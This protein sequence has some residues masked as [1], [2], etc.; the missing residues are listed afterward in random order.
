MAKQKRRYSPEFINYQKFIIKHP[1]YAEMPMP[2]KIK[3][4]IPWVTPGKGT[5]GKARAEWWAK[6]KGELVRQKILT[7][8]AKTSDVA[9]YIHPTKF[10]PCQTCGKSLS[11]EYVYLNMRGK[12]SFK[13]KFPNIDVDEFS[14]LKEVLESIYLLYKQ[15]G[16]KKVVKLFELNLIDLSL[17][18][19]QESFKVQK[20]SLLSPGVMS[21]APDRLDGFHSYNKC[22]RA[23]E[24]TGRSKENL[25]KYGEDRRAYESWADGDWKAASWVMKEFNKAGVSADHIGPIS[26]GFCHAPFF[27]PMTKEENSAKNNRMRHQDVLKLIQ[28]ESEGNQVVSWHTKPVW[29]QWKSNVL[30]DEDARRLSKIMRKHLHRVLLILHEL[31]ER[32]YNEF[33]QSLL[34]PEFAY[35]SIKIIGFDPKSGKYERIKKTPRKIKQYSNNAERY[36]RIAFDSLDKYKAKDNRKSADLDNQDL[37][38]IVSEVIQSLEKNNFSRTKAVLQKELGEISID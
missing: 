32:G 1:S 30:N 11:I 36:V 22:C 5:L 29:D 2:D 10:K 24:D 20:L 7:E 26:C 12:R 14:T 21:N 17:E 4:N 16:L 38:H 8:D 27:N 6:Q 23:K 13:K 34:N 25:N 19:I 18:K 15:D 28:L 9:R 3:D 37:N 33:L 35:F 31:K